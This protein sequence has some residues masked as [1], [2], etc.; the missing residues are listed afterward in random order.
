MQFFTSLL[1]AVSLFW[2]PVFA[3]AEMSWI[4]EL[5]EENLYRGEADNIPVTFVTLR[6]ET[7]SEDPEEYYGGS[8]GELSAGLARVSVTVIRGLD[9]LADSVPFYVPDEKIELTEITLVKVDRLLRSVKKFSTSNNGNVVTYVHGYNIGF[10]KG[11]KRAAIFQQALGLQDRL[12]FFSWPADGNMLKYTWDEADLGWSVPHMAD[13]FENLIKRTGKGNLDIVAHSLGA[14]G[15][16][17][18]LVRMAYRDNK[19]AVINQLVLIAPDIDAA[20]FHQYLHLLRKVA[21]HITIYVSDNDKALKLS[22]EVHGYPRLGE[23]EN[24]LGYDRGVDIIDIS[25]ISMRRPSG[26]LYHLFNEEVIHDLIVLLHTGKKAKQR[27]GLRRMEGDPKGRYV[28]S[29]EE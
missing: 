18:A 22:H 5:I 29:P 20:V 15:A 26:H 6:N 14:R 17:K 27:D 3:K 11:C 21:K 9:Q 10:A 12:L 28:L 2:V 19:K 7:G 16:Y 25:G 23:S 1:I 8:R 24:G 13:F 4:E